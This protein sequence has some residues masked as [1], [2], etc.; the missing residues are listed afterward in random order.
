MHWNIVRDQ[1]EKAQPG[2]IFQDFA[3]ERPMLVHKLNHPVAGLVL[4]LGVAMAM[5]LSLWK[6]HAGTSVDGVK[7]DRLEQSSAGDQEGVL[8]CSQLAW[9]YGCSWELPPEKR[10][11]RTHFRKRRTLFRFSS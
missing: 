2:S 3:V 7:G 1:Q 9:P 5:T 10:E 4:A 11:R 6:K 8:G